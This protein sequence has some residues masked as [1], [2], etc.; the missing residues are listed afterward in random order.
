MP[1]RRGCVI[2]SPIS[3]ILLLLLLFVTRT[4]MR[5]WYLLFCVKFS[6]DRMIKTQCFNFINIFSNNNESG[7]NCPVV[8]TEVVVY[9]CLSRRGKLPGG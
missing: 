1:D 8:N 9:D 7:P 2:L 4:V 6:K 5:Y 3:P